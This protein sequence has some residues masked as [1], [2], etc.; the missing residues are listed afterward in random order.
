MRIRDV[1]LRI[2]YLTGKKKDWPKAYRRAYELHL[3]KREIQW[4]KAQWRYCQANL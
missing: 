4:R 1:D 2:P 3:I